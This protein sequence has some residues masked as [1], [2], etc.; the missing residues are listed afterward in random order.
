MPAHLAFLTQPS[1]GLQSP[2]LH[3]PPPTTT[4]V[5]Y[6]D[7]FTEH[8]ADVEQTIRYSGDTSVG[9]L[10]RLDSVVSEFTSQFPVETPVVTSPAGSDHVA[11]RVQSL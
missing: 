7:D 3:N 2:N 5:G 4:L 11:A 6:D 9:V 10:Q 1:P 8:L